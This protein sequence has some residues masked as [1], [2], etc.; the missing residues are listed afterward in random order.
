MYV[1]LEDSATNV[2][3]EFDVAGIWG[4]SEFLRARVLYPGGSLKVKTDETNK[5]VDENEF[6]VR[7]L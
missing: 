6:R 2:I 3:R 1:K 4:V 7:I 5:N